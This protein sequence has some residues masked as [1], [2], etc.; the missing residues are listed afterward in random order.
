M[1]FNLILID[2]P[3]SFKTWSPKGQG[4]APKYPTMSLEDIIA[5]PVREI[6]DDNCVLFLWTLGWIPP[7]TIADLL[8]NWDF[9][10]K[11]L[12][13]D[14]WKVTQ[15]DLPRGA[16]GY[17]T[18]T[19]SE[20]CILATRGKMVVEPSR[21]P[22]QAIIDA[23]TAHSKKPVAVYEKIERMYPDVSKIELFARNTRS[24]WHSIGN[25]IDGMDIKDAIKLLGVTK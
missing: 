13:F 16:K 9:T 12:A 5:L 10:Y 2:P 22:L 20:Q 21:R 14:W 6:A 18:R 8:V 19:C 11:T 17:Y 15:D 23:P 1:K 4:R 7:Q 25:E 24:G 3:W